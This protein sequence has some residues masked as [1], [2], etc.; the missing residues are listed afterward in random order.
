M[1]RA[2]RTDAKQRVIVRGLR[3]AGV[4]VWITSG[5]GD[6]APDLTTCHRGIFRLVEIKR[7]GGTYTDAQIRFRERC[8]GAI[9]RVETLEEALR[10]H[11]IAQEGKVEGPQAER[12]P[13]PETLP[14]YPARTGAQALI[15]AGEHERLLELERVAR[16]EEGLG[17]IE[18][19]IATT[20]RAVRMAHQFSAERRGGVLA[21]LREEIA[22]VEE[23]D[24]DVHRDSETE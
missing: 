23:A 13:A 12:Q 22:L 20:L 10:A 4:W 15:P 8:P 14:E 21:L 6:G 16:F 17:R 5:V 11:G 7:P 9:W 2:R 19:L 1:G 3:R 18:E 24:G